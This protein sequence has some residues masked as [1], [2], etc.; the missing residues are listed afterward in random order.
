MNLWPLWP[1]NSISSKQHPSHKMVA[2]PLVFIEKTNPKGRVAPKR[3]THVQ[4][5]IY[6]YIIFNIY[7]VL[8][9]PIPPGTYLFEEPTLIPHA[10][11]YQCFQQTSRGK[12]TQVTQCTPLTFPQAPSHLAPPWGWCQHSPRQRLRRQ[13]ALRHAAPQLQAQLRQLPRRAR[14]LFFWPRSPISLRLEEGYP[15]CS[16]SFF[17][18]L[19]FCGVC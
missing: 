12:E 11:T 5:Q 4:I 9:P 6:I 16:S 17:V 8:P 19:F 3:H 2:F 10:I 1:R 7:I 13:A 14:I 18:S 15:F